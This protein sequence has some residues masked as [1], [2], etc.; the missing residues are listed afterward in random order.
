MVL[1]AVVGG[2]VL[3][4]AASGSLQAVGFVAVVLTVPLLASQGLG[5]WG[6]GAGERPEVRGSPSRATG[7]GHWSRASFTS[8]HRMADPLLLLVQSGSARV[9][10]LTA[11]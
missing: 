9:N 2:A 3:A 5:G 10:V 4:I 8:D 11:A 7:A 6:S 1:V